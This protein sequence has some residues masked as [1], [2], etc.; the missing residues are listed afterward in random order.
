MV[1]V[2]VFWPLIGHDTLSHVDNEQFLCGG[3]DSGAATAPALC[4]SYT[5]A[6]NIRDCLIRK[7]G[8][9]DV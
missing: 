3:W 1:E 7:Y 5:D 8:L 9:F 4:S 2:P 6:A